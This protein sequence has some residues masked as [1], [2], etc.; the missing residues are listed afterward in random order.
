MFCRKCGS[1]LMEGAAFCT[2]CGA[3]VPHVD[4]APHDVGN[5]A[6]AEGTAAPEKIAPNEQQA[7]SD[8]VS[9]VQPSGTPSGV[10]PLMPRRPSRTLRTLIVVAACVLVLGIAGSFAYPYVGSVLFGKA[11]A[12]HVQNAADQSAA[13]TPETAT[14]ASLSSIRKELVTAVRLDPRSTQA[15]EALAAFSA[16]MGDLKSA[17]AQVA[18]ILKVDSANAYALLMKDL[19]APESL[20]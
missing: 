15:R 16:S 3:P 4:I 18:A 9:V 11:A 2:K 7:S 12:T 17:D 8:S 10:R 1:Q 19:L 20:P 6:P 13:L 14:E 5:G